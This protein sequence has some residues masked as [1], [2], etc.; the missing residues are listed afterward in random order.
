MTDPLMS[1]KWVRR[2]LVNDTCLRSVQS[3]YRSTW[4][5]RAALDVGK[6]G[7]DVLGEC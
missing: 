2:Y 6:M 1:V 5:V 4:R 7:T 3:R